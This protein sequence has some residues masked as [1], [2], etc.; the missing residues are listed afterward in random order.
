MKENLEKGLCDIQKEVPIKSTKS[1]LY[2]YWNVFFY[3]YS[4]K[5][6]QNFKNEKSKSIDSNLLESIS[7]NN[8]FK[9]NADN[10]CQIKD[11]E[12]IKSSIGLNNNIPL[13]NPNHCRLNLT[14]PNNI[15]SSLFQPQNNNIG[16]GNNYL[17]SNFNGIAPNPPN[18]LF[19]N[20]IPR[21]QSISNNMLL[22]PFSMP[23]VIQN[24]FGNEL[25]P[26]LMGDIENV[27]NLDPTNVPFFQMPIQNPVPLNPLT[28]SIVSTNNIIPNTV[29]PNNF[30][31]T[32][33]NTNIN[34]NSN[35][36]INKNINNIIKVDNIN[37]NNINIHTNT[38]NENENKSIN[39]MDTH[40]KE[41]MN[42][43]DKNESN[44]K[45]EVQI[46]DKINSK[47]Y[48]NASNSGISNI[49]AENSK[50]PIEKEITVASVVIPNKPKY[51]FK[52]K[53][54][55][56]VK[57]EKQ[58]NKLTSKKRKRFLKN[59]KLVF[60]QS[61][62]VNEN[63]EENNSQND[64]GDEENQN[65][66]S[67]NSEKINELI[68]K[69]YKPRGSRYRGVS[70]NGSQWQVLIMVKKKKRYLGSFSNEE[71]AAR[72]YDK[73]ALQHHGI[74]AKTNYDYTKEEIEKIMKGPKLLKIEKEN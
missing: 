23:K 8:I 51:L 6:L 58:N 18:D 13:N 7:I 39:P 55:T 48:T 16:L 73:V 1:F 17:Y 20:Q 30:L 49:V 46:K 12:S 38:K 65:D 31:L 62:K 54:A 25:R 29:I 69:N 64:S 27:N 15:K 66:D 52:T 36:N 56:L 61:D 45:V 60:I 57:D 28:S 33:N 3:F 42:K 35:I 68:Q 22:N 63:K 4:T 47:T 70:K 32:N 34:A 5:L 9:D 71:E 40:V 37:N 44:P 50:K 53:E 67:L 10:L 43:I 41:G 26:N 14:P 24:T 11:K 59:N 21:I 19:M 2:E 72:A 74:K